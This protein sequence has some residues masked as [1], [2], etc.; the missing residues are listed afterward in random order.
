[1][2]TPFQSASKGAA[3]LASVVIRSPEDLPSIDLSRYRLVILANVPQFTAEQVRLLEQSVYDGG[4]LLLA[5]GSLARVDAY[6]TQ[7]Y[8]DGQG[9]MPARLESPTAAD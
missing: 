1:A 4:G 5:P 8:R 6:N 3:D 7:L 9:L 2:L